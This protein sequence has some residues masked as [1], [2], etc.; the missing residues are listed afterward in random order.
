[1]SIID[2]IKELTD[3]EI[4][5]EMKSFVVQLECIGGSL[6]LDTRNLYEFIQYVKESTLNIEYIIGGKSDFKIESDFIKK[7]LIKLFNLDYHNCIIELELEK[8]YNFHFKV[9]MR[10]SVDDLTKKYLLMDYRNFMKDVV[11]IETP[12]LAIEYL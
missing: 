3:E 5:Y 6:T 12:R 1:M 10:N 8:E 7:F 2:E 11:A 9:L 4:W